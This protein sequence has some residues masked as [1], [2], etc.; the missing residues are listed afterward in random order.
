MLARRDRGLLPGQIATD[1]V[2]Y[3]FSEGTT[4][5]WFGSFD[6]LA[7]TRPFGSPLL[8]PDDQS[9]VSR[10]ACPLRRRRAVRPGLVALPAWDRNPPGQ[11]A[12]SRSTA[13]GVCAANRAC[14]S[15]CSCFVCKEE[16]A[17]R[18][19]A[20]GRQMGVSD[21]KIKGR[22]YWDQYIEA[23]TFAARSELQPRFSL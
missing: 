10:S 18:F 20:P 19:R 8:R 22:E 11:S 7:T 3:R 17:R 13:S 6:G 14:A 2:R 16:Q 21:A 1:I 9:A 15:S 12:T 5:V 23:F 4:T